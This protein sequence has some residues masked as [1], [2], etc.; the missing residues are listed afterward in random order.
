MKDFKEA[1]QEVRDSKEFQE[2]EKENDKFYLA[3]GFIELNQKFLPT[4]DWQ[5]GFYNPE[6]DKI[7]TIRCHEGKC[8]I[9][10]EEEIFK[11][12]DSKVF[13]LNLDN[14]KLTFDQIVSIVE[15]FR[16]SKYADENVGKAIV[17]L[18]KLKDS[19]EIFN[20]TMITSRMNTLNVWVDA[21]TGEIIKHKLA[22]LMCY[23][24]DDSEEPI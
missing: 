7:S 5:C 14:V 1:L 3:H 11:R 4:G 22:C 21:S 2:W 8:I 19:D 9:G 12:P 20:F 17:I 15:E 10:G 6:T 23:K 18:Q 24:K 13:K 16:A